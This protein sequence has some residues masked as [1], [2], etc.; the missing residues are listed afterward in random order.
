MP[1]R[2]N[3]HV[4]I[5]TLPSLNWDCRKRFDLEKI[6]HC[7]PFEVS[8]TIENSRGL[9]LKA[10]DMGDYSTYVSSTY[11]EYHETDTNPSIKFGNWIYSGYLSWNYVHHEGGII[12]YS[13]YFVYPMV[14]DNYLMCDTERLK[15]KFHFILFYLFYFFSFFFIDIKIHLRI[16]INIHLNREH[17]TYQTTNL[18]TKTSLQKSIARTLCLII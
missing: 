17:Y 3:V 11:A 10:F 15:A 2:H 1:I 18:K 14:P 8:T 4:W 12:R 7:G 5:Q 16:Y 9:V 6:R 13:E